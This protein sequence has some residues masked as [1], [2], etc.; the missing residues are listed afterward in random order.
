[1]AKGEVAL[2]TG[3]GGGMGQAVVERLIKDGFRVAGIDVVDKGLKEVAGRVDAKSLKTY[4]A[5]LTSEAK[6][7]EVVKR[8]QDEMGPIDAYCST[9]GWVGTTRFAQEESPYWRKVIAINFESILYV[10]HPI[11]TQMIERKKGKIVYI[12]SDAGRVG[13]S[14]EAVYAAMKAALIGFAKSLARENARFNINV[15]VMAPGP[16]ETP[17]LKAEIEE[18]PE[19]VRRMVRLIPFRRMGQ[20]ND[21]AAAISFFCS[22]DSDYITGQVLSVSGGLTMV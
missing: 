14:G 10:T 6:A 21:M 8:I 7:R 15:N 18:D 1:M 20:P 4:V 11:L 16:T 13:T 2:V 9:V 19:L 12:G 3:A 22:P 5:D 17:L